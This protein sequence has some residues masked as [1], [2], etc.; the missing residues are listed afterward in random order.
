[1]ARP[2]AR[3]SS[4]TRW[5]SVRAFA[6]SARRWSVTLFYRLERRARA[7]V[8]A[9]ACATSS[10]G[11]PGDLL[12]ARAPVAC[13]T[14]AV[15]IS[16]PR[17]FIAVAARLR[18]LIAQ[19]RPTGAAW[20]PR[21]AAGTRRVGMRG[22]GYRFRPA[23][24]D[25][26]SCSRESPWTD[27]RSAPGRRSP[28]VAC[29]CGYVAYGVRVTA[30]CATCQYGYISRPNGLPHI[31]WTLSPAAPPSRRRGPIPARY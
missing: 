27:S 14:A 2:V 3:I 28:G 26:A 15:H 21:S 9:G 31:E 12:S 4:S 20:A 23:R 17:P 10:S 25:A 6:R 18:R 13:S 24:L 5:K 22:S 11:P 19:D 7:E 30:L 16:H 29:V 8:S 1:M